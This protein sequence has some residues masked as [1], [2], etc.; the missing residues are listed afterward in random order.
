MVGCMQLINIPECETHA[1]SPKFML[2]FQHSLL[3]YV[4]TKTA[5]NKFLILTRLFLHVNSLI[6]GA[7]IENKVI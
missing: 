1:D 4:T 2:S 3:A 5:Y 7:Q 6:D